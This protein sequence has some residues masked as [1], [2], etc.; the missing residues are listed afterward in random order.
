MARH[1]APV[2]GAYLGA[3]LASYAVAI[4]LLILRL[5]ISGPSAA[6]LLI[7]FFLTQVAVASLGWGRASRLFALT[8]LWQSYAPAR[9]IPADASEPVPDDGHAV[10]GGSMFRDLG[11]RKPIARRG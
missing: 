6:E 7:G 1:P 9:G 2:L 10:P 5:R 8:A 3:T 4:P 11:P